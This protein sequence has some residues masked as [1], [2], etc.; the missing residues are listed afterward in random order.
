[1]SHLGSFW[2]IWGH[3]WA[4]V[5]HF[6]SFLDKFAESS[7]L[8]AGSLESRDSL[9]EC[10]V[11]VTGYSALDR[12]DLFYKI[13]STPYNPPCDQSLQ[14]TERT[15][16]KSR[17]ACASQ[18]SARLPHK[19]PPPRHK[20]CAKQ[21]SCYTSPVCKLHYGLVMEA[22]LC[23]SMRSRVQCRGCFDARSCHKHS[24]HPL[25]VS[26]TYTYFHSQRLTQ[27]SRSH[28]F[29]TLLQPTTVY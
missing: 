29:T 17:R 27:I 8:F 16:R 28:T 21:C 13:F 3:I 24:L 22:R 25:P 1:M 5:G 23:N 14:C 20:L 7:N 15:G 4:T 11:C 6:G 26:L 18:S 10:M 12:A 19:K 9:L 2:A